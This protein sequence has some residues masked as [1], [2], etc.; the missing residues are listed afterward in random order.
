MRLFS[1]QAQLRLASLSGHDTSPCSGGRVAHALRRILGA[2]LLAGLA[3][4]P[5]QALAQSAACAA[6]E[7][8]ANYDFTSGTWPGG[9]TS[10]NLTVYTGTGG[11]VVMATSVSGTS[12]INGTPNIGLR[13][14]SNNSLNIEV[15]RPDNTTNNIVTLAFSRAITKLQVTTGDIDYSSSNYRDRMTVTGVNAIA[16]ASN[17]TGAAATGDVSVVGTVATA[18]N[19]ASCSDSSTDCNVTWNFA[20]PVKTVTIV[21]DNGTLSGGSN[22][23]TQY[24]GIFNI[25]FCVPTVAQV[26]VAKTTTGGV[27]TFNFT[28]TNLA[29]NPAVTTA[30][31]GTQAFGSFINASA[32][33]T[34][35]SVI[36][37]VPSGWTH[38]TAAASCTDSNRTV[39]GNASGNLGTLSGTTQSLASGVMTPGAQITCAFTNRKSATLTLRKTWVNGATGD[40]ATVTSSG[41]TNAASSGASVSSGSNTTTGSSVTVFAGESGTIGESFSVGSAGN[42]NASLSCTGTS[43]L[44]GNTLTVGAADTAITCT[45]TNSRPTLTLEK[46][47]AGATTSCVATGNTYTIT[48]GDVTAGSRANTASADAD[49]VGSINVAPDTDTETVTTAGTPTASLTLDKTSS[50][51]DTNGNTVLGDAG[52]VI[53][54]GFAVTNTGTLALVNVVVSDPLLPGL[55]CTIANLAAGATTSCVATG[56]TY[57]ITAG[58]V[59]AGSRANTASADADDV[60]SINVAP[61]TDTETVTTA[62]TP[63]A[64]LT[65]DKTSSVADT[66]GNTVLGDAGDVITYGFAVTNTGTLALVNVVVSDPLLPGL[67]CTIANLAVGA[68]TSCVATGNTYTITAGDVTAGSRANTA[69]ADADDVGSINVAPDTDT[70]TVTTAGTPTA[71][72]TLDKTSSVADTNGNTVLGDAGDVITYG[73]AVTNTGTLALVNVVVSDPLLPGLSCT[74]ANL[75]AGATTSCVA[76]GNTYTITA[77]DVTAGSRANTASADADDVGSINVAPATDTVTVTT[78]NLKP[79]AVGDSYDVTEAG[80]LDVPAGSGVLANDQP[81]DAPTTVTSFDA[82][83]SNGGTV[84]VNPDGSFSYTQS[85]GFVGTDAFTYTICDGNGDCATATVTITIRPK[86][87]KLHLAKVVNPKNVHVGGLATYTLTI[88]NLSALTV[89]N[90]QVVDVPPKGFSL[91]PGSAR[92]ED[93]DNQM[94]TTGSSPITFSNVDIA[95]NGT[96]TITYLMKV[97]AAL[98]SGTYNNQATVYQLGIAVSNTA[99]AGVVLEAANDPVFDQ[100]RIL[101]K[102]FD[103]QN[104]DG[105][106]DPGE[107]GIPGVRLATVEGLLVETDAEGRYHLEGLSVSNAMR[108]QNFLVKVDASTLPPGSVFTTENPLLRR[109]TPAVPVRFDFGV[110]LPGQKPQQMDKVDVVPEQNLHLGTIYFDTDSATVGPD[111]RGAIEEAAAAIERNHGGLVQIAGFADLRASAEY[112]QELAMRRAKAVYEIIVE[113]LSPEAKSNL[114]VEVGQDVVKS[115]EGK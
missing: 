79:G 113:K 5:A 61:D 56:N 88:S 84:V 78:V 40:T 104:A 63:T 108:G 66:N 70:E 92:I 10:N 103:D 34:A 72:L 96:A 17:P 35:T 86:A 18:S 46:T 114:R 20:S 44:S 105:W 90:A 36:E 110:K 101:G 80:T 93:A 41:F 27:G 94:G 30:T 15:N 48:A 45:Y 19:A 95:P 55:S 102:V 58:D 9:S 47:A 24:V 42:Y 111:Q 11:N 14:G 99:N 4:L 54:Y 67:S 71:S 57:T 115:G 76:T 1:N 23:T 59:T 29:S 60:G 28:N 3:M 39:S 2:T 81:G 32:V 51:A 107:L 85:P 83:S 64:S 52:D 49:D 53:T 38:T 6:G 75:A 43:G 16:G 98:P 106:Q 33:N 100:T 50:V 12:F 21:Y 112:N 82:V 8:Q 22:P 91:V 37:T 109:I 89:V 31:A 69:S 68:T 13:G 77:G 26:R 65:L 87:G 97:G 73:F 62:G 74:I 25:D 7:T